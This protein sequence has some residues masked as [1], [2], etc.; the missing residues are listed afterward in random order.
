[1]GRRYIYLLFLI[2]CHKFRPHVGKYTVRPMDPMGYRMYLTFKW[3]VS[4]AMFVY[5]EG[6]S[7]IITVYILLY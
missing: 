4:I 7:M 5:L 6:I 3:R 2:I 1:M